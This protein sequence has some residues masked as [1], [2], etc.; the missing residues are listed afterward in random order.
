MEK[1][2]A[3]RR[4]AALSG[5]AKPVAGLYR[6]ALTFRYLKLEEPAPS[7]GSNGGNGDGIT[8]E[9]RAKITDEIDGLLAENR[10][11]IPQKSLEYSAKRRGS[12]L[13]I[14]SNIVIFGI[15]IGAGFAIFG[16]LNH[17]EQ[18]IATGQATVQGAENKLIAAMRKQT[19]QELASKDQAILD[20]QKKLQAVS[21]KQQQLKEQADSELKA[22]QQALQADFDAKVAAEKAR[23]EKQGLSAAA[24]SRQLEAFQTARERELTAQMATA[25][26]QADQEVAAQQKSLAS[27]A[28]QYQSDLDAAQRQRIQAQTEAAQREAGLRSQYAQGLQAAEAARVSVSQEL[29][30]LRAQREKEQLVLDQLLAGYARVNSALQRQDLVEARKDLD[31]LRAY[32]N[33]PSIADLPTVQKRRDVEMFLIDSLDDLVRS[34]GAPA[35]SPVQTG[36]EAAAQLRS[37]SDLVA[38]GDAFSKAGNLS[39]ARNAYLQALRIVP[40]VDRA[41][42]ALDEMRSSEDLRRKQAADAGLQKA[43][44][45]YQAGDFSAS[46][47]QYRQAVG[48]LVGDAAL[49]NQL[50]DNVMNAG[51]RVL[52]ADDLSALAALRTDQQKRQAILKRLQ[53]M[54]SQYLAYAALSQQSAAAEPAR[55]K[56]L[57]S[58]LQAKILLRQILDS[59]PIRAQYP[60]L[61]SD[62]ERY[63]TAL[64]QL[65]RAEGRAEAAAQMTSLVDGVA[66]AGGAAL[67]PAAAGPLGAN[68][69]LSLLDHMQQLLSGK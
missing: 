9:E 26:R 16:L 23:L 61:S 33:D 38:Q 7:H 47:W 41:H 58:L 66:G 31:S 60:T 37:I 14:L 10:K 56:S 68:A 21:Q 22:Q 15:F 52:A 25:R 53:D 5:E 28:S 34:R 19:E 27:L 48:L 35:S 67:P 55:D 54:R 49:A 50:T 44:L 65:G 32:L 17:Q 39:D 62:V 11:Q 46:L 2:R 42:G 45:F 4:F 24:Q 40:S 1:G 63:F 29:A 69:V 51:Y 3:V 6:K 36:S 64:E 18:F 20:A 57:A 59:A 30:R 43:N 8:A 13:P 12:L